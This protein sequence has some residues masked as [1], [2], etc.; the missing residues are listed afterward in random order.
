MNS[1]AFVAKANP[2]YPPFFAKGGTAKTIASETRT[3]RYKPVY[4]PPLKKG[5]G[6]GFASSANTPNSTRQRSTRGQAG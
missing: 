1:V 4:L 6:G 5:A 2:R 3:S